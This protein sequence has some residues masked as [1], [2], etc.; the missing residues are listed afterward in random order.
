VQKTARA[1]AH[2]DLVQKPDAGHEAPQAD[3]PQSSAAVQATSC[4]VQDTS[5]EMSIGPLAQARG[6]LAFK[7]R[8]AVSVQLVLDDEGR[9]RLFPQLGASDM[10]LLSRLISQM[11]NAAT[12][13]K[14]VDYQ[15]IQVMIE[16]IQGIAPRDA[17]EI[18]V[19]AHKTQ[20]HMALMAAHCRLANAHP[21]AFD[22]A[23]RAINNL[24]RTLL[25]LQDALKR[26][27][28]GG[29]QRVTVRHVSVSDGSQAIVGNVSHTAARKQTPAITHSQ[30]APIEIIEEREREPIPVRS[31]SESSS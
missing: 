22:S 8:D 12:W 11:A 6:W 24:T 28:S 13:T 27:R 29:E 7:V 20:I 9:S 26:H 25:L 2:S 14:L 18:V 10:Q 21:D 3:A 30:Q 23:T 1:K 19:A 31:E 15:T 16:F 4:D 17:T 5:W